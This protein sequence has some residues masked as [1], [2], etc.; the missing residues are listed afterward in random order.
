MKA[1]IL[2]L[3]IVLLI[4][5]APAEAQD[6]AS[7]EKRARELVSII[8][9]GDR[10]RFEDYV[11]NNFE[12]QFRDLPMEEHLNF[13]SNVYDSS[14]GFEVTGVRSFEGGLITLNVRS[15]LTGEPE[16][17]AVRIEDK[18]PYRITG[19]GLRPPLPEP[20]AK[21]L[22]EA[23][24][25]REMESFMKKLG[26]ADVFSGTVLLAKDGKPVYKGVFGIAN[27]DFDVPNRFDTKFN[28]GSMNKMFTSIAIAKLIETGK[29]A[30]EDPLSKFLPD[31]PDAESAK[32]IKVK[33]LLS[34]T[35]GLGGYFSERWSQRARGSIRTVD[36]MIALA[37]EDESL[38]FEPGTERRYSNTGMLVLGKIIEVASGESYFDFVRKYVLKPAGMENTGCFEL[39]KVNK[40]LA[41][42]YEKE[43]TADGVT[44][45]NNIFTH[46]M[47]GGPQGGCYSTAEDL[48]KFSTALQA[49]KIVGKD[50]VEQFT[51]PKPELN[52]P[53]YGFGFHTLPDGSRFG[54]GGGFM[55][56]GA[57]MDVFRGTGWTA[58]V[59]SNYGGGAETVGSKMARI[60]SAQ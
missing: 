3:A 56:I 51:T 9:L 37:K 48:L 57:N 49:G 34:H 36:D 17:I 44:F 8:N 6:R 42:G 26:D 43:F 55:G 22:S 39:D 32:K 2:A 24:I 7:A 50:L 4:G 33:H 19:I 29:V 53:R 54:H 47:R 35:S 18:E 13:Y 27:R 30:L 31:F 52:S 12:G 1:I 46:V 20:N 40:N 59:L 10:A 15:K 45:S 38:R 23:E 28:L 60:V 25:A 21:K 58:I 14:R 11:K 5:L 41:V 16:G